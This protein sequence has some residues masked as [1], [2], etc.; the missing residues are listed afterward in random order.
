MAGRR[1]DNAIAIGCRAPLDVHNPTG[2]GQAEGVSDAHPAGKDPRPPPYDIPFGCLVPEQVN[3]LLLAGRCISGDHDAHASYRFQTICMATGAA[4][5]FAAAESVRR[6]VQ[7]RDVD[8]RA[9]QYQLGMKP[10]E[11]ST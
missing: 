10:M 5:G 4:A 2:P 7:P 1:W 8:V 6:N 9:V 11:G 3:G